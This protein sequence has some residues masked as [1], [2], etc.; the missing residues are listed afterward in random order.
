MKMNPKG[1]VPVLKHGDKVVVESDDILKYIDAN[2]GQAGELSQ[3][4]FAF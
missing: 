2:F 1:L 4:D 3:V